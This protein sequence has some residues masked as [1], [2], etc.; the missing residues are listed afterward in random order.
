MVG[1]RI[2][3]KTSCENLC[4]SGSSWTSPNGPTLNPFDPERSAG[5]SSS[6]SAVAVRLLMWNLV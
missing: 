1:G 5:G 4:F 6:G 3:G 2:V